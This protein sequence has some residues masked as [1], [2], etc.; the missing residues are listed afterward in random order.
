MS[1]CIAHPSGLW[2]VPQSTTHDAPV[3]AHPYLSLAAVHADAARFSAH[4][5]ASNVA[6]RVG[7]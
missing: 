2:N 4:A 5:F 6:N 1:P 3:H 7:V